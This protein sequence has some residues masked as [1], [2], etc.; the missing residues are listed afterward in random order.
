MVAASTGVAEAAAGEKVRGFAH[1]AAGEGGVLLQGEVPTAALGGN[2]PL[3]HIGRDEIGEEALV[4]PGKPAS[5]GHPALGGAAALPGG[6]V[7]ISRGVL[8][9]TML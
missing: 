9:P 1:G 5:T 2:Q 3:T 6:G 8:K 4:E 7:L